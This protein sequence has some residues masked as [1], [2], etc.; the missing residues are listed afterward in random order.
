MAARAREGGQGRGYGDFQTP[1]RFAEA[2]CGKLKE[3]YGLAPKVIVEP[4]CGEGNLIAAAMSAFPEARRAFGIEIDGRHLEKAGRL[5]RSVETPCELRLFNSDVFSFDFGNV[6]AALSPEDGILIVGNPPWV[7]NSELS[8]LGSRN[9][10]PKNNLKGWKGLDAI[11]G[12]GNFDISE[13]IALRLLAAFSG[14]GATL[15]MLVKASVARNLVRDADRL[16]L[17]FRSADLHVFDAREVFGAS[18]E[19]GLLVIREGVPGDG[20][21]SVR[22]FGTGAALRRFGWRRGAFFSDL[23]APGSEAD[24]ECPFAW[25]QGVKHDC[26]A[27]ME[28]T[29]CR[30]GGFVNGLG[31]MAR[32]PVGG[33]V[34]PLLKGSELRTPVAGVPRRH[35]VVTQRRIGEDTARLKAEDPEVWSYLTRH[36]E[37][38]GLR[39][40]AVYR[41]SPEFSVFGVGPYAFARYKVGISG[42]HKEPRFSLAAGAP[43]VMLDDTC[44]YLSFEEPG[45][46]AATLA[47]LNSRLCAELLGSVAFPDSKRPFTKGVLKRIDLGKLA[48]A[49]GRDYIEGYLREAVPGVA[50][51]GHDLDGYLRRLNGDG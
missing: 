47:L 16:G 33:S 4:T 30:D 38:L 22:D 35:V 20:S 10:P 12:K 24:G 2:V 32:L 6:T 14:L 51:T 9:L 17:E 11:T 46:A 43:P 45:D 13:A 21:C 34:F 7:T 26:V 8:S 50:V 19:A 28:L 49:L 44:Y 25:R 5:L 41:G 37:R 48:S 18:C 31:E 15:A 42:F 27:V 1:P 36:R 29:P 40:S 23:D 3:L 39:R